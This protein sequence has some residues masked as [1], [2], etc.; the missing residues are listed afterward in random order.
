MNIGGRIKTIFSLIGH[1][2]SPSKWVLI[3]M[4]IILLFAGILL[5]LTNGLSYIAP[6]VYS[7]F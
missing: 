4:L 2:L 5:W 1:F 6:F 3:P 7:L